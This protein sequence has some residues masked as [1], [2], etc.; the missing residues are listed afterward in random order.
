MTTPRRRRGGTRASQRL[1]AEVLREESTCWLRLEGCT[2]VATQIDHIYPVSDHPELELVRSN[3]RGACRSCNQRRGRLPVDALPG[4]ATQ[5]K[6]L[7]F[8]G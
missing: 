7:G 1:R 3:C 4:R 2:I 5:S 6:G 8:F